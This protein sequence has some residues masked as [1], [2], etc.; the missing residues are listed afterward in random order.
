MTGQTGPGHEQP[1]AG[2]VTV[3]LTNALATSDGNGPGAKR[4]PAA[5][6]A[7]LVR[8]KVAV[9]GPHPPHGFHR[10]PW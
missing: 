1:D 7:A 6:A 4:L 2:M 10:G 5:E 9:Y 8:G 3:Y